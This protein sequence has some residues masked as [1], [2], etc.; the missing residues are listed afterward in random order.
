MPLNP[1]NHL[2]VLILCA[3]PLPAIPAWGQAEVA[4][5]WSAFQ[6]KPPPGGT[7]QRLAGGFLS[8]RLDLWGSPWSLDMDLSSQTG[9]D[10]D[11]VYFKHRMFLAGPRYTWPLQRKLDLYAHVLGGCGSLQANGAGQSDRTLHGALTAGLGLD[12]HLSGSI[13]LR[14]QA[15]GVM[16]G[17]TGSAQWN[18]RYSL[19][20][21][22]RFGGGQA[23]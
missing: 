23:P 9:T 8:G 13:L 1:A 11:G 15:D 6:L 20:M 14:G 10:A 18:P 7:H 16:T 5:G 22:F 4:A 19:G 3:G 17:Y 21:A 12:L 2:A